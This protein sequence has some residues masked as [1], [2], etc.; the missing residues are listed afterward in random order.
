MEAGNEIVV[1]ETPVG[2]LGIVQERDGKHE[3]K[4]QEVEQ[5][6]LDDFSVELRVYYY[7]SWWLTYIHTCYVLTIC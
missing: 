4:P 6:I 7:E 2:P 5:T 3:L 1:S